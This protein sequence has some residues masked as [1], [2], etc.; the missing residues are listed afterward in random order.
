MSILHNLL[1]KV[2][3]T[4]V[5]SAELDKD[6]I[7][8]F[9]TAFDGITKSIDAIVRLIETELPGWWWQCGCASLSSDAAPAARQGSANLDGL[10]SVAIVTLQGSCD[11]SYR[12]PVRI[13]GDQ[14]Q[15]DDRG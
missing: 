13:V 9:P 3:S 6:I 5:D 14:R 12:Y 2:N 15:A 7:A 10:W 8:A 1:Q 11:R 4:P